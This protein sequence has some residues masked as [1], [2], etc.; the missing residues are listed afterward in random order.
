[1]RRL[2]ANA[3]ILD[4]AN[5][6]VFAG[7]FSIVDGLFEYVEH[8]P[9]PRE[10]K[11]ETVDLNG[12]Y[13]VPGFIDA[14]MHIESSNVTPEVFAK[15]ALKKGTVAVL[16][17]PHE[18][19]NVFGV[20]GVRFMIE[21]SRDQPL[22]IYTAIPSCVP[23]TRMPVETPNARITGRDVE[24]LSK[25]KTV[26]AL[27]EVMDYLGLLSENEEL[28]EIVKAG[29]GADLLMEG[30]CPTL[31]GLELSRYSFWIRSDHT[32]TDPVKIE[33][34]LQKGMHVMLQRKSLT[35]ETV[36]FIMKLKD[37]SRLLLVTDDV[38][39]RVLIK[40]HLNGIV[41]KAIENGWEP[42]EAIA[43][44]TLRPATYLG[45]SHLGLI[46][47][48]RK[49]SFFTC[50]SLE[51]IEPVEVFV[52][53]TELV[54]LET[55][56]TLGVERLRQSI[57]LR[58]VTRN[59]FKL[60]NEDFTG[61]IDTK[62]VTMNTRNSLT[63]LGIESVSFREGFPNTEGSDLVQVKVFARGSENPGK[64]GGLLRGL[65]LKR[66][67]LAST[68]AHDSHNILVVG[69]SPDEMANA[70]NYL[71]ENSGGM[72]FLQNGQP[73]FLP[74]NI[75][76]IITDAPVERVAKIYEELESALKDAGVTHD[77]PLI[78][79]TVLS[80]TV[81]PLYKFSD[82]GL[83]DVERGKVIPLTGE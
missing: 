37:R 80:L 77:N 66:G 83:I 55:A 53:G 62:V 9:V 27:G 64:G 59:D 6:K 15:A 58:K 79:L 60:L 23:A 38:P 11:G 51:S 72:V 10:L 70:V 30:H 32:L 17:D 65:G 56:P 12:S 74:L 76:G 16:A 4:V 20:D 63:E 35:T 75:G 69:K 78:F 48:G 31:K 29:K 68:F 73:V 39:A 14:H 2:F 43:S 34:Q 5:Q 57:K 7:W 18:M 8:G 1:M 22:E 41:N 21:N 33:E 3:R 82:L 44:A 71:L 13:V 49:A 47:P 40:E 42:L 81:S 46:A 52:A 19:A 67:A 54:K 25:E 28:L 61:I 50:R 26:I 36:S 45:F 24:A